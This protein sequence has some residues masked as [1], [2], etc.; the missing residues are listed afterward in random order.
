MKRLITILSVLFT[1]FSV[2]AE[3]ELLLDYYPNRIV[4]GDDFLW[5]A[6][7]K[8][9]LQYDKK[10]AAVSLAPFSL[11]DDGFID[12]ESDKPYCL[13]VD[14]E[15]NLWIA[16]RSTLYT[17]NVKDLSLHAVSTKFPNYWIC[18]ALTTA[19][20]NQ[21]W[22]IVYNGFLVISESG[23]EINYQS[24]PYYTTNSSQK[25][26][27]PSAV[28]FD[29]AGN[30][31]IAN[32]EGV[33]YKC[34]IGYKKSGTDS[35]VTILDAMDITCNSIIIDKAGNPW[36]ACSDGIRSYNVADGSMKDSFKTRDGTPIDIPYTAV[37]IDREGNLW[38]SSS[39]NLLKYDGKNFTSYTCE[40]YKDARSILCDGNIVWIYTKNNKLLKFE[41]DNFSISSLYVNPA[42]IKTEAELLQ[43]IKAYISSGNL[44]VSGNTEI[45]H[46][47]VC[48]ISGKQIISRPCT[49][50]SYVVVSNVPFTRGIY[51]IKVS[52]CSGAT[53]VKVVVE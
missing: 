8:E 32:S 37:D 22:G 13:F 21:I 16:K 12:P 44:Y 11:P 34:S 29:S 42:G 31:W 38:F 45:T 23:R 15:S 41:N 33:G 24:N 1:I 48:D 47:E 43:Q 52:A 5:I 50:Q 26:S 46:I 49:G 18:T 36:F 10:T 7:N 6:N 40:A 28:K 35:Y 51:I 39:H 14:A 20:N 3:N 19:P 9:L 30:L 53:T 25:L 27:K 17:Y 2:Q 4:N